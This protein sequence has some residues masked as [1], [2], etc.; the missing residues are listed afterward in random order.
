MGLN[1][2]F[3]GN[4]ESKTLLFGKGSTRGDYT[5]YLLLLKGRGKI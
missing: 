5:V 2:C 1:H 4:N 3:L